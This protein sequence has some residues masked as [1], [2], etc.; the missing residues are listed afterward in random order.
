[1]K[2]YNYTIEEMVDIF[3]SELKTFYPKE[4]I[5]GFI[6]WSFKH[7]CNYSS[8]DLTIHSKS[9]LSNAH[10][11]PLLIIIERLKTFEPIQYIIG[12]TEF[13]GLK[14]KVNPNV[15][16]PRPETEELVDWII[17]D[18]KDKSITILDIGIGSGCIAIALKKN[19]PLAII[20]A[21][22]I[23]E[24]ALNIAKEN[25]LLNEVS[26][27]FRKINIL[28][29]TERNTLHGIDLIVS[30]PPYIANQEKYQMEKN[31]LD[32]EPHL[33]L[34]VPDEN[35]LL[36]YKEILDFAIEKFNK[37]GVVYCEINENKVLELINLFG[38]KGLKDFEFRKDIRGKDR[39]MKVII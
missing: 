32:Y 3:E 4:E 30:N 34:F 24:N 8:I 36:F 21:I 10:S 28:D 26:I 1:M 29:K 39:M 35:P 23:S 25:A 9:F 13:Y 22:D 6:K 19:L 16:I 2:N 11:E 14:I 27:D 31:V 15:L 18:N 7:V 12:E 20:I 17:K 38:E 37:E 33:A 5:K